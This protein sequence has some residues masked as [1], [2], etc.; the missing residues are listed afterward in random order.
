[1]SSMVGILM[2]GLLL[3]GCASGSSHAASHS[4][5]RTQ[6][7][8]TQPP[9]PIAPAAPQGSAHL[10]TPELLS[11]ALRDPRARM[12]IGP[13]PL[14]GVEGPLSTCRGPSRGAMI[15]VTKARE[16]AMYDMSTYLR[17]SDTMDGV[18]SLEARYARSAPDPLSATLDG[19]RRCGTSGHRL[20]V[21]LRQGD[22]PAVRYSLGPPT[23]SI[24]TLVAIPIGHRTIVAV[25]VSHPP[26]STRFARR[27]GGLLPSEREIISLAIARAHASAP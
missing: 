16:V 4:P 12:N 7:F 26:S 3:A 17:A 10:I 18:A 1:M 13:V 5:A 22:R 24:I 6:S 25:A 11:T 21:H 8:A 20:I 27:R 15:W 23:H 14:S 19:L 9:A 2:C